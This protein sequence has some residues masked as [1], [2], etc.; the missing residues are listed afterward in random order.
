VKAS[1]G[2]NFF[3]GIGYCAIGRALGRRVLLQLHDGSFETWYQEQ[4]RFGRITIRAGL[5]I[6]SELIVLSEY[7]RS[8]VSG[9]Q[10][11]RPIH[12]VANGVETEKALPRSN[13][14]HKEFRVV[15]IGALGR[16][17]G[18]FDIVAAAA[19]LKEEPIRFLFAGPDEFGEQEKLLAYTRTLGVLN[20]IDFLGTI[21]GQRKWQLLA[22][23]D[24]FLFPSYIENMPNAVL[25]AMAAGLPVVCTPVGALPEIFQKKEGAIFIPPADPVAIERELRH[26]RASPEL[27]RAMGRQNRLEVETR[28]SFRRVQEMLDAVYQGNGADDVHIMPR[29]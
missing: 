5:R 15:T 20:Q 18:H 13:L 1:S 3:Q 12:V 14:E 7:W 28:F 25:E 6:P 26:L 23:A 29:F 24:V 9:L 22:E 27:R 10:P 16:Q 8:F 11:L 4:G 17:K 21:T 2:I 19:R